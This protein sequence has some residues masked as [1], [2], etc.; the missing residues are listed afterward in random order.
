MSFTLNYRCSGGV[1]DFSDEF[2]HQESQG[3]M[4]FSVSSLFYS[5]NK[6]YDE[7][8]GRFLIFDTKVIAGTMK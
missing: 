5:K 6:F 4:N 7:N 8:T 2:Q 1:H 3:N